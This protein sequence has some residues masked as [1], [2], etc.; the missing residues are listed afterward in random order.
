[1]APKIL[2]PRIASVSFLEPR[3]ALESLPKPRMASKN[4]LIS[5]NSGGSFTG[6]QAMVIDHLG[7]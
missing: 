5:R 3:L 2:K 7:L 6:A 4:S 1:M